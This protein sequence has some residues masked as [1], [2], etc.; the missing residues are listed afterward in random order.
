MLHC[1]SVFNNVHVA[2]D[3]SCTMSWKN[4]H[5]ILTYICTNVFRF[6][7]LFDSVWFSSPLVRLDA[8]SSWA[9]SVYCRHFKHDQCSII[10]DKHT[11]RLQC[12]V[13]LRRHI[14][15]LKCFRNVLVRFKRCLATSQHPFSKLLS[16]CSFAEKYY[17]PA[18]R[19]KH[20]RKTLSVIITPCL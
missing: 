2:N 6:Q 16:I 5:Y 4:E 18:W 13:D 7:R 10:R 12:H 9:G 14:G 8:L 1:P 17:R 3:A 19:R 11:F 20:F 15:L